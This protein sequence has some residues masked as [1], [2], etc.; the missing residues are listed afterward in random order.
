MPQPRAVKERIVQDLSTRLKETD[1]VYLTDL[2]GLDVGEVTELRSRLRAES[3][4][5]RVIKNTLTRLA[6][7]DAGLPDLGETLD[8]P[9]ALVFSADPVTPAKILIEFGKDHEERPRIKGGFLT[10][11]IIDASQAVTLSELPGRD[12]LLA[13]TVGG[14]A[15]PISGLVFTLSG[16]LSGLVRTLSAL[17]Q[18]KA[19]Q[20]ER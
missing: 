5:C 3:V 4:E 13:R 16:V 2:T 12:E 20:Q 8:G 14:I 19:T 17:S 10:G 7:A 6:V 1:S 11:E 18:Q 15:A 9:T